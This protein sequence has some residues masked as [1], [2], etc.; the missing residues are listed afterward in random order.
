MD[1]L[2]EHLF[3]QHVQAMGFDIADAVVLTPKRVY[4]FDTSVS[5]QAMAPVR[6]VRR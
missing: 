3:V 4:V 1:Q 6:R 5:P 2:R